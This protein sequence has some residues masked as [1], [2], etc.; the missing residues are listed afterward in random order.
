MGSKPFWSGRS[1]KLKLFVDGQAVTI[2][3]T[4]WSISPYGTEAQD[5]VCGDVRSENQTLVEGYNIGITCLMRDVD[6]IN[7]LVGNTENDDALVMP[8][9]TSMG[10]LLKPLDGTTKAFS[11][12]AVTIGLWEWAVGGQSERSTVT[13]PMKARYVKKVSLF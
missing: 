7:I 5:T 9:S 10:F 6:E 13:I 2:N 12:D 1:A 4:Q 3:V 11:A 8:F